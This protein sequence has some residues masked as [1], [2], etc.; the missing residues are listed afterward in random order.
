MDILSS[1]QKK[2]NTFTDKERSIADYIL[3]EGNH[4][5][6]MNISVLAST[7]GVSDGTITR[8]CKK[9]GQ[10]SF[11]ELKIQLGSA[12]A[13]NKI[14][15]SDDLVTQVYDFYKTVIEHSNQMIDRKALEYLADQIAGAGNIY[16]FGVG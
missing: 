11:A 10:K 15:H 8:F 9:V 3:K 4:I 5:R 14:A 2:Y 1:I 16:I 6:N 13:G 12:G 7:V